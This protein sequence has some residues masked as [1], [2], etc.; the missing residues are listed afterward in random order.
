MVENRTLTSDEIG[1][2]AGLIID[3]PDHYTVLGVDRNASN[4]DI[5]T[6]YCIAVEYFHPLKAR[7]LTES[8]SV[9]HWKLSSAFVR[10]EEAFAILSSHN[11]RKVYDENL[12][13]RPGSS[14]PHDSGDNSWLRR[15]EISD[16]T[17]EMLE[18]PRPKRV[19][20]ERRRVE[21]LPLSLPLRVTFE[22]Q[23]QELTHTEDVS[24]LGIRF[25]LSRRIEPGSQLR[26]ELP[27]PKH[28]RT[29]SSDD[30]LYVVN[31]FVIH[32]SRNNRKWRVVAE[33]IL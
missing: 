5:R 30:E 33:F 7:Q 14:F 32:V 16:L 8:D 18:P 24:P 31:A 26:L 1:L 25:R 12:N 20:I 4:E 17:H 27:L 9:M 15:S 6:A 19:L 13:C 3:E 11:R 2:L 22:R 23:W 21:R 28:L 10:I 29:Q